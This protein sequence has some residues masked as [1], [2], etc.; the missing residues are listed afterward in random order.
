MRT[1]GV[2]VMALL[3]IV[4]PAQGKDE[5]FD[6]PMARALVGTPDGKLWIS[7]YRDIRIWDAATGRLVRTIVPDEKADKVILMA[8]RVTGDSKTV[9]AMTPSTIEGYAIATGKLIFQKKLG[10]DGFASFDVSR[11]G[12]I[13]V[14]GGYNNEVYVYDTATEKEVRRIVGDR[15]TLTAMENAG[16]AIRG[17][18]QPVGTVAL[19]PDGKLLAMVALIDWTVRVYDVKSGQQKHAFPSNNPSHCAHAVFSPDN[20]YLVMNRFAGPGL[21]QGKEFVSVWEMQT[22]KLHRE[23]EQGAMYGFAVSPDWKWMAAAGTGFLHGQWGGELNIWDRATGKLRCTIVGP[24]N[25]LYPVL[26]F[27]RDGKTLVDWND[28]TLEMWDADTGKKIR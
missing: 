22:G 1:I 8:L 5:K 11:D 28:T 27:S 10:G 16:T 23:H 17:H 6:H 12:K 19:S 21:H 4:E 15:T 20:A 25:R 9:W 26:A 14:A 13:V 2:F 24:K 18:P 7:S 3:C